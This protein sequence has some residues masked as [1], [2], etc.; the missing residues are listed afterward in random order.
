MITSINIFKK[1]NENYPNSWDFNTFNN[2]KTF[3]SRIDYCNKTLHRIGSGTSRI[4]YQIDDEKV[5]KLAKNEKGIAQNDIEIQYSNYSDI[6]D[7]T[8]EIFNHDQNDIWLEMEVANKLTT[9]IF[10]NIVGY[11][12]KDFVAAMSFQ[13]YSNNPSK[14]IYIM[15]NL[16]SL[17][18]CGQMNLYMLCYHLYQIMIYRLV[19]Y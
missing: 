3:K 12:F 9:N 6:S 16:M 5:L 19:T 13:Y 18:K 15:I 2:L 14:Y 8:A 17:M 10:K 11:S 4:V 1:I 7:I